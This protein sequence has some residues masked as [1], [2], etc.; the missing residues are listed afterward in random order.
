LKL[1]LK[2]KIYVVLFLISL[3]SIF[4][5]DAALN[6]KKIEKF[7]KSLTLPLNASITVD[8]NELCP[9]EQSV[10]TFEGFDGSPNYTFTYTI[11]G[12]PEEEISTTDEETSI[13]YTTEL[14]TSGTFTYKLIKVEDGNGTI[15]DVDEE[16][17]ITVTDPPT[18]SFTFSNDG[19]CSG[20]IIQF[21]SNSSGE[22]TLSYNWNFGDGSTSTEQNPD[23]VYNIEGNGSQIFSVSLIVTDANGCNTTEI[24]DIQVQ[25][26]PD[27]TF[28]SG[29][30]SFVN[31]SDGSSES[32]NLELF[33]SSA[34]SS[35]ITS[36][37]INWGDGTDTETINGFP[38]NGSGII[39]PYPNGVFT[40]S[41]S[42]INEKW[43]FKYSKL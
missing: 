20:E 36:Y 15:E 39:H 35:E 7:Q 25:K 37:T 8:D 23:K 1:I 17:V 6:F 22:G 29:S 12:G 41:I 28:F 26:I 30:G 43:M 38:T 40:L 19:A 4:N 27:I 11:N 24:K 5:S 14:T 42:A 3:F 13:S 16:I 9:G 18:I 2:H 21:T 33:N 10:I 31:C 34:S 32:F